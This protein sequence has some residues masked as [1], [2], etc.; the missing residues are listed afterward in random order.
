MARGMARRRNQ[1][2]FTGDD[3]VGFDQGVQTGLD[4]RN[5]GIIHHLCRVDR[6]LA[7]DRRRRRCCLQRRDLSLPMRPFD[8]GEQVIRLG[9][10]RHPLAVDQHRVPADMVDMEMGAQ[11]RGD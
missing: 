5:D 8:P 9:E 11:H 4:D 1:R 2:D 10:G 3:M 6:Q 7:L